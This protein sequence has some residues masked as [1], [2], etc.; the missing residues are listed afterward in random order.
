MECVVNLCPNSETSV[1]QG[2]VLHDE[3]LD[4]VYLRHLSAEY[5]L[6]LSADV[7]TDT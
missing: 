1:I 3:N 7:L 5:Q 6:I 4:H 2:T